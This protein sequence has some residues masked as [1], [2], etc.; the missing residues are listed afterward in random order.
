METPLGIR[1]R[2]QKQ[3]L[4][5]EDHKTSTFHRRASGEMQSGRRYMSTLWRRYRDCNTLLWQCREAK[6]TWEKLRRILERAGQRNVLQS[7]LLGSIDAALSGFRTNQGVF[8][9]TVAATQAIWKDR[10]QQYFRNRR[11]N[12]PIAVILKTAQQEADSQINPSAND[13]DWN[14]R[15]EAS[16]DLRPHPRRK[17]PRTWLLQSSDKSAAPKKGAGHSSDGSI[18]S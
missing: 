16:A 3:N 8:H 13:T 17:R 15:L 6:S 2:D 7:T 14:R 12:T 1:N 5:M 18:H 11:S 4:V 10:N 9:L